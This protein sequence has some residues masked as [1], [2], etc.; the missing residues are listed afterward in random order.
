MEGLFD[1]MRSGPAPDPDWVNMM[2]KWSKEELDSS[3]SEKRLIFDHINKISIEVYI[4]TFK[5]KFGEFDNKTE[6]KIENLFS[7]GYCYYFAKMLQL[8][9][10]GGCI[11]KPWPIGHFIYAY[12]D[13][14]YDIRGEYVPTEHECECIIPF[15]LPYFI[16][17]ECLRLHELDYLHNVDFEDDTSREAFN[18]YE[19]DYFEQGKR[20]TEIIDKYDYCILVF[21]VYGRIYKLKNEGKL[22]VSVD[23]FDPIYDMPE[24]NEEIYK[25]V[26]HYYKWVE[27]D[28]F[29][30]LCRISDLIS[31]QY[32]LYLIKYKGEKDESN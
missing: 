12:K 13:K 5:S 28:R 9:Y 10:P 14:Y 2:R 31:K 17:E 26:K 20:K 29:C 16:N 8:A 21:L 27:Y 7:D 24:Q 25:I 30:E 19:I 32:E 1:S 3:I 4:K 6:E 23:S 18:K 15:I 11:C 22:R